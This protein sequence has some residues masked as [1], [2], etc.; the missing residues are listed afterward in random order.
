MNNPYSP[1][2]NTGKEDTNSILLPMLRLIEKFFSFFKR[3]KLEGYFK[4]PM[5]TTKQTS[6]KNSLFLTITKLE[7]FHKFNNHLKCGSSEEKIWAEKQ[8][9]IHLREPTFAKNHQNSK[10]YWLEKGAK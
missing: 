8:L 7:E 4:I 9:R 5:F 6:M 3:K 1:Y 10:K 2:S